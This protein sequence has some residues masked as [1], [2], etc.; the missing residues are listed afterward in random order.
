MSTISFVGTMPDQIARFK[1]VSPRAYIGLVERDGDGHQIHVIH[2]WHYLGS[3]RDA[4][5]ARLLDKVAPGFDADGYKI[6]CK[7]ILSG[8]AEIILL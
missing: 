5:E 4:D 2:H 6:L 8:R 1:M 7:P 3:V